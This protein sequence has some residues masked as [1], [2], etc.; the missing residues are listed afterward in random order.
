MASVGMKGLRY[1]LLNTTGTTYGIPKIMG[2]AINAS[3]SPNFAEASLY[4]DD[5]LKE[6]IS[7][8]QSATVSL[9]V[10]DDDDAVFSELLGKTIDD[11][12][13]V[14]SSNINDNPPYVAFGYIV[15]KIKN[16]VQKWRAQFFP[17]IK[18]KPFVPEASTKG[19]SIEFSPITIEGMTVA[20]DIGIWESHIEVASEAD[21]IEELENFFKNGGGI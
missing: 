14:V 16:N 9:T 15:T 18:F 13:G 11:E 10:D 12:T 4:A 21:A 3:I 7:S 1:A 20:N 8:F 6:Y 5:T 19:D 2:G 17:K